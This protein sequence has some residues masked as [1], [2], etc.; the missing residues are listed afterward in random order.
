MNLIN[1]L[2]HHFLK[3]KPNVD[4]Q[5]DIQKCRNITPP[6]FLKKMFAYKNTMPLLKH[7]LKFYRTDSVTSEKFYYIGTVYST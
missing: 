6:Y 2:F 7:N 4:T 3:K 5:T 1:S